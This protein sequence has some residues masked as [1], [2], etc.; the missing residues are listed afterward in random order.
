MQYTKKKKKKQGFP[1]NKSLLNPK[2]SILKKINVSFFVCFSFGKYRLSFGTLSIHQKCFMR[3]TPPKS[4]CISDLDYANPWFI[5][6]YH[7]H[8]IIHTTY[9]RHS[10]EETINI[11]YRTVG[12]SSWWSFIIFS[13]VSIDS[14]IS[15]QLAK[16][17]CTLRSTRNEQ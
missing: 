9:F 1:M 15:F 14:H 11:F 13:I 8:S 2:E 5:T 16:S 3:I 7:F 6:E 12:F 10:W 17:S 4:S